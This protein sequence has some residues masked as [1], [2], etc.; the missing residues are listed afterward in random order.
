MRSP[1]L[2]CLAIAAGMLAGGCGMLDAQL[3]TRTACLTI[4]GVPIPGSTASGSVQTGV[5]FDLG[6]VLPALS[7]PGV[8]YRLTLQELDLSPGPG[9]TAEDL[10]GIHELEVSVLAPAGTNLP[11]PELIHYVRGPGAPPA[12]IA[13]MAQGDVDLAPYVAGATITFHAVASGTLPAEPWTADARACFLLDIDV[14]YASL[15]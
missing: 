2:V 13:A 7:R 3:E 4:G 6:D 10:G 11:D 14:R 8:S 5:A 12:R 1:S 15:P 9:S